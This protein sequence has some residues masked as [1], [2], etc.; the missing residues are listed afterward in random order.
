MTG[1][2]NT[3]NSIISALSLGSKGIKSALSLFTAFTA[4]RVAGRGANALIGGL[5]GMVDPQSTARAGMRTGVIGRNSA[6][7]IN[8][9]IVRELQSIRALIAQKINN[10][11][12]GRNQVTGPYDEYNRFREARSA[13]AQMSGKGSVTIGDLKKQLSGLSA[14]NQNLLMSG[15]AGTFAAATD[16]IIDKYKPENRKAVRL[17]ER[18]L[19]NQRKSAQITA[20]EYYTA[21]QDPGLLKKAM[22]KAGVQKDNPAYQK[23]IDSRCEMKIPEGESKEEFIKRTMEGFTKL[24]FICKK[25]NWNEIVCVVHGGTIMAILSEISGLDYYDFYVKNAET[26]ELIIEDDKYEIPYYSICGRI[27][28]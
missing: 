14:S 4:L 16:A 15:N 22:T 20:E 19:N 18:F 23:W 9:P 6:Q 13:V 12:L 17:G 8:Q 11:N 5:G 7:A 28:S 3:V 21:L 27:H 1:V 10:S 25:N 26:R 2:L 24:L